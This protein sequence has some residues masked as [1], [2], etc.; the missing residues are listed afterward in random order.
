MPISTTYCP[1]LKAESTLWKVE[2]LLKFN[3]RISIHITLKPA[4]FDPNVGPG[5]GFDILKIP[6]YLNCMMYLTKFS[7]AIDLDL[8][9]P[10]V[11]FSIDRL[12]RDLQPR[13]RHWLRQADDVPVFVTLSFDQNQII[14]NTAYSINTA[15]LYYSIQYIV[16]Y[17]V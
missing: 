1:A 2:Y 10:V 3:S 13:R 11:D 6:K 7:A 14:I 15:M 4:I 16:Q 8:L 5:V 17:T 9:E 12:H